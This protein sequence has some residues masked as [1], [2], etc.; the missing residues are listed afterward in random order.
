MNISNIEV[1]NTYKN[2]KQLC[3]VLDVST[4]T[5]TSKMAQLK[6]FERYFKYEK[7]GHSFIITHVHEIPLPE[8]HNKTKYIP[9]I[10]KLIIDKCIQFGNDGELFISKSELMKE[11]RMINENYT[12]AKYKQLRL[13]KHMDITLEEIEDFYKTSDDLLKRNIEAAL[14]SLR[15]QSL[16]FWSHTM[17]LCFIDT[18]AE[19]NINNEIKACKQ[20]E[21]NEFGEQSV[22][23]TTV[24]PV[25]FRIYRKATK[26]EIELVLQTE[27]EVMEMFNCNSLND[28]FKKNISHKFYKEVRDELFDKANIYFYYNS[29]E[30]TINEKHILSKWKELS[31]I[32][33]EL[34]ERETAMN[35][36]NNDIIEK[37]NTNSERRSNRAN[38]DENKDNKEKLKMRSNDNYI[39]NTYKLTDTL[40]NKDANP[41]RYSIKNLKGN[42]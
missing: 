12:Y 17:T 41:L 3:S 5:G 28:I 32:Q 14:N 15:N 21:V 11:L 4:K 13:A 35:S 16:I 33:L 22:S 6:D 18:V 38:N 24:D 20:E 10:E 8:N 7:K 30:I 26:E 2:Y 36:L 29:Y 42:K 40:I 19:T 37:I 9:T 34:E 39:N 23:F 1:G 27:R 31:D 25:T